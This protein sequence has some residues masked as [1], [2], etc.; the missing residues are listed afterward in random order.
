MIKFFRNLRRQLLSENKIS[1]Y[2][3]YALGE[4]ILVVIGILIALQINNLNENKKSRQ[5]ERLLLV[6]MQSNLQSDLKDITYNIVWNE[7]RTVSNRIVKRALQHQWP[8]NDSLNYHFANIFGNF[9]LAEN[10]SAWE[11]LKSVGLDLISNDSLRN[12]VS[13]LYS[14]KYNYL[15]NL[16]KG[17]DDRYQWE[18]LYP[19]ILEHISL[20]GFGGEGKPKDYTA[21]MTDETFIQVINMN[22]SFREYMQQQYQEIEMMIISLIEQIED[23]LETLDH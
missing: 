20:E 18:Y 6:G 12:A 4:I 9:Q 8:F 23:H 13:N 21:L 15:E 14:N 3:I 19:Q 1:K 11:N 5:K 22:I 16:E 10:T 17:L 2:S 7:Q